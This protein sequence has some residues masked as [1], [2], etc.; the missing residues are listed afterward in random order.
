VV[1]LEAIATLDEQ[2]T[3]GRST[4]E[5][6]WILGEEIASSQTPLLAMTLLGEEIAS[7]HSP[8]LAMTILG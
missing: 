1:G 4:A 2:C 3:V 6:T 5:K 8:L 7:S